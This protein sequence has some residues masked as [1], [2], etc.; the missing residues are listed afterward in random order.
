MEIRQLEYFIAVAE[1]LHFGRAAARLHVAQPSVSDQIRRL[2]REFGGQLFQRT[3]RRVELTKLGQMF[4]PEARQALAQLH[5]AAD[6]VRRSAHAASQ[7]L[8]IGY[9][10][11]LGPRLL[12]LAVP[13]MA[14]LCPDIEVVP[15]SMSTPD[16]L[17]ALRT[18]RLDIGLTWSPSPDPKLAT[19]LITAEPLVA[20]LPATHPLTQCEELTVQ[21]LEGLPLV[22]WHRETNPHLYDQ[23][24]TML[25]TGGLPV[26][27]T[28]H[29]TG[30]DRMLTIVVAGAGTAI[31]VPSVADMRPTPGAEYRPFAAPAPTVDCTLVWRGADDSA[32]TRAFVDVIRTLKTKESFRSQ[33]DRT[34][35]QHRPAAPLKP[36][37]GTITPAN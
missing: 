16:Q 10:T 2:E 22:L 9:A 18:D 15:Q 20:A 32:S 30:L 35:G 11:D 6:R 7:V 21:D 28:H 36:S 33:L 4:L 23:V 34:A 12:Q 27:V 17:D 25:G 31:T 8:T 1:E 5:H 37:Q 26:R 19:M 3:S 29:A 13:L 14:K 24:T